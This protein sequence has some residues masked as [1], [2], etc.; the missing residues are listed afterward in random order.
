MTTAVNAGIIRLKRKLKPLGVDTLCD[1][2]KIMF[3]TDRSRL[4]FTLTGEQSGPSD[5]EL[6]MPQDYL[7][8]AL[9]RIEGIVKARL[10]LNQTIYARACKI[11]KVEQADAL[12]FFDKYHLLGATKSAI[13]TGLFYEDELF[14][15]ASFSKGRKMRRL[16]AGQLSFELIRFCTKDG[17]TITGGLSRLIRHFCKQKDPGDIMTYVDRQLSDGASFVKAGFKVVGETPPNY[18]LIERDNFKRIFLKEK[19]K[20]YDQKTYYLTCNSGN[21]KMIFTLHDH[22]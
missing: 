9:P 7:V 3:S 11:K 2:G 12:A 18:F 21:L 19:P 8:T 17:Y 20:S 4:V 16:P 10:H 14:A 22:E 15:C 1:D 6:V 13:Q 5:A